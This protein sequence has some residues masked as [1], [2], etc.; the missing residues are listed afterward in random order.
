M[1]KIVRIM[2][3]KVGADFALKLKGLPQKVV[4]QSVEVPSGVSTCK[5]MC[6]VRVYLGIA[7]A[8]S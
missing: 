4:Y 5:S 7:V 1:I 6:L 2:N 3:L 8:S